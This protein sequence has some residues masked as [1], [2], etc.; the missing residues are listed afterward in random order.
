MTFEQLLALLGDE[1]VFETGLLLA[2]DV[3]PRYVHRQLSEWVSTS[4]LWQL[5]RGLYAPAPPYQR[6]PPHPYLIANRLSPGSYVSLQSALAYYGLIPEHVA[7]V[8]SVTSRRPHQWSNPAGTFLFRRLQPALLFGYRQIA[9]GGGQRAFVGKPEK[10]LLDLIYLQRAADDDYIES[11]RLQH[12]ERLDLSELR[13]LA[14]QFG[15]PTMERATDHV[16]RLAELERE[17]YEPL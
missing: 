6:T 13:A 7:A 11:L 2:G 16:I 4:K 10:A 15:K 1:P 3:S 5:R 12:L 9:V 14:G 8:A 17:S